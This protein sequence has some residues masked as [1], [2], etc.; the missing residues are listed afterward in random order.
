MTHV[1]IQFYRKKLSLWPRSLGLI[2]MVL[3][4][5]SCS[6]YKSTGRKQFEERASGNVNTEVETARLA[7]ENDEEDCW[8]QPK[9]EGLWFVEESKKESKELLVRSQGEEEIEVCTIPINGG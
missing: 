9:N 4:L 2:S 7:I 3:L 1:S 8:T 6:A 5:A